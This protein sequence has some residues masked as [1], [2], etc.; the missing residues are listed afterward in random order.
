MPQDLFGE[1]TTWALTGEARPVDYV[2][3]SVRLTQGEVP[4]AKNV[5]K[6]EC[7][8]CGVK[9]TGA[10]QHRKTCVHNWPNVRPSEW[11]VGQRKRAQ[12]GLGR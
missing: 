1:D 12:I 7:D 4:P 6:D 8:G 9:L 5:P 10:H 2:T 3:P 11:T